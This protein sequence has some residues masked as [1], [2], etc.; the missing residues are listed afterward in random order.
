MTTHSVA[1]AFPPVDQHYLLQARQMQ[2]VVRGAHPARGVRTLVPGD[3]AVRRVAPRVP[4]EGFSFFLEAI[5]I[6]STAGADCH[7]GRTC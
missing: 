1:A 7:H 4:I 5:F 3:G 2:T 6:E